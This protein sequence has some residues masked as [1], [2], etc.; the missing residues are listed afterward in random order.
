MAGHARHGLAEERVDV[1]VAA[2]E[3]GDFAAGVLG[4]GPAAEAGAFELRGERALERQDLQ[5]VLGQLEVAD[6]VGA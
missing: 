6:D 5:A 1:G 3:R 4:V 2:G